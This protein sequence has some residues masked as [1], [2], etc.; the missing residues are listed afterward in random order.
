MYAK[1]EE[2]HMKEPKTKPGAL[3]APVINARKRRLKCRFVARE[4]GI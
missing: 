4:N 3:S 2:P 1:M